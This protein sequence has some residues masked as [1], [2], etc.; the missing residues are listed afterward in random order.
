MYP[1]PD[2]SWMQPSGRHA[3]S[4]NDE[5]TGAH[6]LPTGREV[7]GRRR[8]LESWERRTDGR[9][10][11]TVISG[12]GLDES[13]EFSRHASDGPELSTPESASR[14]FSS[15]EQNGPEQNGREQNSWEQRGWETRGW[16]TTGGSGRGWEPSTGERRGPDGSRRPGHLRAIP[17]ER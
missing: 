6:R 12:S 14:N 3:V 4:G 2:P 8:R 17:G 10:D 1:A 11:L 13:G 9:P 7:G 16:E 5:D 15:P